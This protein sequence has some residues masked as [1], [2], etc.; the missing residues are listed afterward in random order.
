MNIKRRSTLGA[1]LVAATFATTGCNEFL[2]V[3][4]P[5]VIEASTVDA[6]QDAETFSLSAQTDFWDAFDNVAVYGAFFSGEAWVDDTFPTRNDIARRTID[7]QNGTLNGEVFAPLVSSIAAN[8]RVLKLLQGT[9]GENS[10]SAARAALSSGLAIELMA[11]TFCQG[12]IS[13][14]LQNLGAPLTTEQTLNEAIQRL[15][16][17]VAL[18]TSLR[19]QEI[20]NAAR[21]GLARAYLQKGDL[22]NAASEA[23]KVPSSFVY[24]ALKVDD[25]SQRGR[26]GNTQYFFTVL[27][28]NLVVPPYYRALNDPRVP[29][30]RDKQP[31][32]GQGGQLV[33]HAQAKYTSWRQPVRLASGLEARYIAAEAELKRNNPAPALTLINERRAVAGLGIFAGVGTGAILRELLDQK[34]RDFYLEGKHLG[35]WRRNPEATPYVPAAG[36]TYYNPAVGGAFGTDRCLIV[37]EQETSN[38]PNFPKS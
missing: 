22:A 32:T 26:L 27:R 23:A 13:T 28:P 24:N 36:S 34:S 35:D 38:N 17:A 5:T 11:E 2:E 29:S 18:G 14:D 3:E 6:V 10:I 37:P 20:V 7:P 30:T 8:E 1:A 19:N 21:V 4:N 31:P 16:R 9:A 12:V 15:Q 25:P 33:F